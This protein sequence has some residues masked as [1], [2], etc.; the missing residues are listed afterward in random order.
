[1]ATVINN[2]GESADTF[3]SSLMLGAILLV[4][5]FFGI[6]FIGMPYLRGGS[7]NGDTSEQPA[8]PIENVQNNVPAPEDSAEGDTNINIPDKIDVNVEGMPG[9]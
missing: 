8:A 7:S 2:S 4:V 1:M 3:G 5:A 9:Q 6:W